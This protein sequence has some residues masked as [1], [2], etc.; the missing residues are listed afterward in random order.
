MNFCNVIGRITKDP[1]IKLT[2]SGKKFINFC[3]AVNRRVKGEDVS[4]FIDCIAWEKTAELI[5]QYCKKGS[6]VGIT[7][8]IQTRNFERQD[9]SKVK[10]TEILVNEI[11]FIGGNKTTANRSTASEV[12][13]NNTAEEIPE[14]NYN[15]VSDTLPFEV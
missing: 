11:D 15:E 7:G 14:I 9:G 13:Q 10:V 6:Q 5:A 4:D 8:K 3:V 2:S 1:E 12:S